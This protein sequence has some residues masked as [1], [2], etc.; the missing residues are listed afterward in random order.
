MA[1][2]PHGIER[3][4]VYDPADG[5]TVQFSDVEAGNS[6][7]N[8][9]QQAE[10]DQQ[11]PS[12]NRYYGGDLSEAQIRARDSGGL[13]AQLRTWLAANTRLSY[14]FQGPSFC[15]LW[16]ETDRLMNPKPIT[17]EGRAVGRA[18]FVDF[19]TR[20]EGHGE[21]AIHRQVNL[22]RH[23]ADASGSTYDQTIVFPLQGPLLTAS[24]SATAGTTGT[25][26]IRAKNFAGAT[27]ISSQATL[28]EGRNSTGITLPAN[29]YQVQVQV[30]GDW[31]ISDAALRVG[32]EN[33]YV[34]I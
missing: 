9:G 10:N 1:V 3:V 7:V 17:I 25:I 20:R 2:F 24:V 5:T 13:L 27:L 33:A 19:G 12:G 30:T 32:A 29:T 31:T 8:P 23:L 18:D 21:H 14:V 15:V 26:T 22:L 4:A 34:E 16:Y 11:D 6:N 28:G